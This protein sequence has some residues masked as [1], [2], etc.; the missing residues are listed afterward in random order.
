MQKQDSSTT[1]DPNLGVAGSKACVTLPRCEMV[2]GPS[3]ISDLKGS[4]LS[5]HFANATQSACT[6]VSLLGLFLSAALGPA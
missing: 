2:N 3:S 5:S 1:Q 6:R 4:H